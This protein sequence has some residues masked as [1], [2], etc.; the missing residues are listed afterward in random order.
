[1]SHTPIDKPEPL[2]RRVNRLAHAIGQMEADKLKKT[3]L[4]KLR[5]AERAGS[6]PADLQALVAA[7]EADATR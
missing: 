5:Q 2:R 4:D 3:M 1:M 6:G 7:W